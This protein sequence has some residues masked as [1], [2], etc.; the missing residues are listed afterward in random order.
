MLDLI[1]DAKTDTIESGRVYAPFDLGLKKLYENNFALASLS[2]IAQLRIHEGVNSFSFKKTSLV[3]EGVL[4]IPQG[5]H[6][7]IRNSPILD[8]AQEATRISDKG[9][10]FYLNPNQLQKALADSIDLPRR[11]VKIPAKLIGSDEFCAYAFRG[12]NN[13]KAYGNFLHSIGIDHLSLCVMGN[14]FVDKQPKPFVRQIV[15]G[16]YAEVENPDLY[17]CGSS[18][19]DTRWIRGVRSLPQISN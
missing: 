9:Q 6:K 2:D 12:S 4:F 15:I 3:S 5:E 7:L 10:E 16:G 8:A 14:E 17:L 13:A 1:I 18:L 11:D 19:W